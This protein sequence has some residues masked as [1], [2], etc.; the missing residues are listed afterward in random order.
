MGKKYII[1]ENQYN[2]LLEQE[3]SFVTSLYNRVKNKPIIKKIESLYDENVSTFIDNI[4]SNFSVLKNKGQILKNEVKKSLTDPESFLQKNYKEIENNQIQEQ[5]GAV[6]LFFVVAI[7]LIILI[8]KSKFCQTDSDATSK[9]QSLVGKRI[10]LYND[11]DEQMLYGT[12][13]VGRISFLDCSKSDS[14]SKVLINTDYA[15]ECKSNPSRIDNKLYRTTKEKV[16]TFTVKKTDEAFNEEFTDEV[17][18]LVGGFCKKPEADFAVNT[19][20]RNSNKMV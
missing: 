13:K 6:V 7:L 15:I 20:L 11:I 12:I 9:L 14:R 4:V 17:Q 18:K 16:G 5:L 2:V 10:N 1:T 19:D 8:K 3:N